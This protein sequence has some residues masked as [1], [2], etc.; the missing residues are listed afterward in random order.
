MYAL[1]SAPLFT[2]GRCG[3]CVGYFRPIQPEMTIFWTSLV[4][5]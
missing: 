3:V 1:N 2:A 5:S 4:P